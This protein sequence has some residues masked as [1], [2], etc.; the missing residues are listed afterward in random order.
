MSAIYQFI[1]GKRMSVFSGHKR[2]PWVFAVLAVIVMLPCL[3]SGFMEDDHM[4]IM[5]LKGLSDNLPSIQGNH[6]LDMHTTAD[7]KPENTLKFM[8][9]GRFPWWTAEHYKH[10]MFRPLSALTHYVDWH[11]L[12]QRAWPMHATNILLYAAAVFVLVLMYRRFLS[13]AW[14]AA[15]AGLMYLLNASNAAAVGWISA[16]NA[17]L[18][19]I[20]I[21]LVIYFHDRWRRDGWLP[22]RWLALASLCVGLLSAEGAVACGAYLAGHALFLDKGSLTRKFARLLP[23]LFV[24]IVWRIIYVNLGYG[25]SDTLLYTDPLAQPGRFSMNLTHHLPTLLFFLFFGGEPGIVAFL[26]YP[27][28]IPGLA[29][30]FIG[31]I[32]VGWML[33]PLLKE[34]ATARFFAL[35]TILSIV[36][37]SSSF[38]QG[39]EL[40]NPGIGAFALIALFLEY[41]LQGK[42]LQPESALYRKTATALAAVWLILHIP[43]SAIT[44]PATAY[45]ASKA[46]TLI[47]DKLNETAPRDADFSTLVTAY[48]PGDVLTYVLPI[49]RYAYGGPIPQHGRVLCAGAQSVEFERLDERSLAMR[50]DEAFLRPPYCQVFRDVKQSPMRAGDIVRLTGFE[51]HIQ[52]VTPDGRPTEVLFRFDVPLEHPSLRW[53][54]YNN[55]AGGYK[56]FELPA[57][58]EKVTIK[59]PSLKNLANTWFLNK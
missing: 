11:F 4:T 28:N 26:P 58:G 20:F 50:P 8:E 33:W 35:G 40:M 36:P 29:V 5:R 46:P 56:P 16:R 30:I 19:A 3:G 24:V 49:M 2:L 7:G 13:P 43:V 9:E 10:A 48:L 27:W 54:T 31:T 52:S 57:V 6:L 55:D 14:V 37:I 47:E 45:T 53:V 18:P 25:V 21:I 38:P 59:A 34:N 15:L 17:P 23:Y 32:S 44:A 22:G 42:Q 12:G 51:A 1:C 41:R 39:R